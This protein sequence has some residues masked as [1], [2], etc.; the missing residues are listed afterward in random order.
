MKQQKGFTLIELMIVVVIVSLLA[1]IA[2]PAYQD[3][4]LRG[5][6]TEAMTELSTLKVKLEQ[7]YQDYQ[8]YVGFDCAADSVGTAKY[9]TYVCTIPSATMFTATATGIPGSQT[10]GFIYKI[11]ETGAKETT[12]VPTNWTSSGTCWI[13]K[14]GGIC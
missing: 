4:I 6:L 14:K 13:T 8:T 11:T 10:D 3:Y 7:H 5:K 9:F 1:S 12:T 2:L